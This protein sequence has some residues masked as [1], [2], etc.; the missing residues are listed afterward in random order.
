MAAQIEETKRNPVTVRIHY[1]THAVYAAIFIAIIACASIGFRRRNSLM[2]KLSF[3]MFFGLGVFCI[4]ITSLLRVGAAAQS[5]RKSKNG[6]N[7][8]GKTWN[9]PSIALCVLRLI[10]YAIVMLC[11]FIGYK[12]KNY[13]L[14]I[15]AIVVG[16]IFLLYHLL[17]IIFTKVQF[18]CK[19][20]RNAM[21]EKEAQEAEEEVRQDA[22]KIQESRELMERQGLL[23]VYTDAECPLPERIRAYIL[24][25]DED[26]MNLYEQKW[27][28]SGGYLPPSF[29]FNAGTR[30]NDIRIAIISHVTSTLKQRQQGSGGADVVPP[31]ALHNGDG[32]PP[33]SGEGVDDVVPS[34]PP[35]PYTLQQQQPPPN[36]AYPASGQYL[37]TSHQDGVY[38]PPHEDEVHPLGEGYQQQAPSLQLQ[39]QQQQQQL[40]G[41]HHTQGA[42]TLY[43]SLAEYTAK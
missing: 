17:R 16:T 28:Q 20:V 43:P 10:P 36:G 26:L 14:F 19:D 31:S 18:F 29:C 33:Q 40:V 2:F 37:H 22:K 27:L 30:A 42:S 35:P 8:E 5:Y 24:L 39:Q 34:A 13:K 7:S 9:S 1:C 6:A 21:L 15:S 25:N 38:P 11:M 32:A 4:G 12:K 3:L 41:G 23:H